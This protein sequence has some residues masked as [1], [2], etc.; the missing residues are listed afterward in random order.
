MKNTSIPLSV[1]PILGDGNCA[2]TSYLYGLH[3]QQ[4][5]PADAREL[6]DS[7]RQHVLKDWAG[8][9]WEKD[10]PA[11]LRGHDNC[12]TREQYIATFLSEPTRHLDRTIFYL[13]QSLR[14]AERGSVE[15]GEEARQPVPHVYLIVS[16]SMPPWPVGNAA[17]AR[18][19][20]DSDHGGAAGSEADDAVHV[21]RVDTQPTVTRVPGST[22]AQH[23]MVIVLEHQ[24]YSPLCVASQVGPP[25][26]LHALDSPLVQACD[27]GMRQSVQRSFPEGHLFTVDEVRTMPHVFPRLVQ[28]YDNCIKREKPIKC[29]IHI[30][31][32]KSCDEKNGPCHEG[33]MSWSA[34]EKAEQS[35]CQDQHRD[36]R[37]HV[38]EQPLKT[39][40]RAL[41]P[42]ALEASPQ[43]L[44][45][46]KKKSRTKADQS[47]AL[48]PPAANGGEEAP[49][50]TTDCNGMAA[51][52]TLCID[53]GPMEVVSAEQLA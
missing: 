24:H 37:K 23:A 26:T 7:L 42:Q 29:V 16:D 41:Q 27:L 38:V 25:V 20:A 39:N 33:P 35:R 22:N 45:K 12:H 14:L 52:I 10:I 15:G 32:H 28:Y 47:T 34:L 18:A 31:R 48:R 21:L 1:A 4:P 2:L 3:S 43:P 51:L 11:S 50:A 6:R 19:A 49:D 40:K 46:K 9:R 8:G 13:L 53:Q 30:R 5:A 36:Q 17:A 44:K